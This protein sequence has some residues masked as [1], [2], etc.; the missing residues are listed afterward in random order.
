[1]ENQ[2]LLPLLILEFIPLLNKRDKEICEQIKK[3]DIIIPN[4]TAR[5]VYSIVQQLFQ[6]QLKHSAVCGSIFKLLFNIKRD[7][8]TKRV[9][10]SLSDN[11][12]KKGIPEIN[13]INSIAREQLIHYY[14][15][16]ETKYLDGIKIIVNSLRKR[17]S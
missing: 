14:T 2:N 7:P 4:D 3:D 9:I 12:L 11:I 15:N 13:R 8:L 5:N 6:Q 16:C 1:M 17:K 10:I